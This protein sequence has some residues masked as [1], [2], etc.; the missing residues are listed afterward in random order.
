MCHDAGMDWELINRLATA[1]G[2]NRNT[3]YQWRNRGAVPKMYHL[4]LL[5]MA[6]AARL[7]V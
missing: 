2:V 1:C 4:M 3:L 5:D 7:D 6:R